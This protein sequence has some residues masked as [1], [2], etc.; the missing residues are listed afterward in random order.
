M[1]LPADLTEH[2]PH[3]M[4]RYGSAFLERMFLFEDGAGSLHE[5]TNS[6]LFRLHSFWLL[7]LVCGLMAQD[8]F[9][10]KVQNSQAWLLVVGDDEPPVRTEG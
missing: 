7:V 10:T 9:T 3:G 6:N 5:H 4:S 2:L 8:S 1:L